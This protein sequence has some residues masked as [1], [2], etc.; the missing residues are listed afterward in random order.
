MAAH[1][2]LMKEALGEIL[3]VDPKLL[4][5]KARTHEK[6]GAIGRGE[7]MAAYATVLLHL[8]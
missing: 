8:S 5:I 6:M 4:G 7:A 3:S 1:I 2:P